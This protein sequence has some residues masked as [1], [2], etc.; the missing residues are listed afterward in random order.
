[1]EKPKVKKEEIEDTESTIEESE[2]AQKTKMPKVDKEETERL[3]KF[4]E[5]LRSR[6]AP[7]PKAK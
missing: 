2:I 7:Q 6:K 4:N 5:E 1:M 3:R